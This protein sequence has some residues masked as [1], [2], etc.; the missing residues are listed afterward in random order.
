VIETSYTLR[1]A[2]LLTAT[3]GFLDAYTYI[4]RD[5]VFANVQ[6]ANVIFGAMAVSGQHWGDALGRLWPI[7]AFFAG[8]LT[9]SHIKSRT[10]SKLLRHPLRWVM[11]SQSAA[12]AVIGFVPTSVS[13]SLVTIPLSYLAAN[14]VGL[15]R[16]VGEVPYMPIATTGN[17]MRL[18]EAGYTGFVDG[19]PDSRKAFRIYAVLIATFAAGAAIGAL[20]S[21]HWGVKAIWVPAVFLALTLVLF[22]IDERLG[23]EP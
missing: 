8:V 5:G 14:Q 19:Q 1:F 21:F 3:N 6:T 15:F 10:S 9:S 11:A 23:L 13:P 7:L 4:T 20:A 17:L 16:N 22:V 2:V 18:A 12:L